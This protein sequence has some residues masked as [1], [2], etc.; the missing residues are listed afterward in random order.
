MCCFKEETKEE[1]IKIEEKGTPVEE[2]KEEKVGEKETRKDSSKEKEEEFNPKDL[3][4][5]D[6]EDISILVLTLTIER[7]IKLY[8]KLIEKL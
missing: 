5:E 7:Q 1:E 8:E 3:S 4:E 2:E 6:C